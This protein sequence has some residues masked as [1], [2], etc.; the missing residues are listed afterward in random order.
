MYILV[1]KG[2]TFFIIK[3]K[4]KMLV[5]RYDKYLVMESLVNTV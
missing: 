4:K 5:R 3:L 1:K 2:D